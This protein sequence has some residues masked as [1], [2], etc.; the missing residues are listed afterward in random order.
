MTKAI[1]R[2]INYVGNGLNIPS[3]KKE[4]QFVASG[5]LDKVTG[6]WVTVDK[7]GKITGIAS[8]MVWTVK[9]G[10]N[11]EGSF[12]KVIGP[13]TNGYHITGISTSNEVATD[14]D[15]TT[16]TVAGKTI[17]HSNGDILITINYAKNPD[18][19]KPVVDQR[20]IVVT[21]HDIKNNQDVSGYTKDSGNE[22]V[23]TKFSYDTKGNI[24]KLTS[25]GYKV[26]NP[27]IKIPTTIS[28]GNQHLVIYVD[29]NVISVTPDKPGNGLKHDDLQ[30]TVT[31]TVK[32]VVNGDQSK[33]PSDKMASLHFN[34]TTYYDSVTKKW[35]DASGNELKD[36]TK[37]II[38]TAQDGNQFDTVIS[39]IVS[40]YHVTNVSDNYNDGNGN[41]KAIKNID[42]TSQD[43]TAIVTYDKDAEPTKNQG[44]LIVTVHDITDNKDLDKYG[45]N[46]GTQDVGTK[47]SYDKD[48]NIKTLTEKGYEV[49]NPDVTIPTE[50]TKGNHTVTI[51]VKHT[52]TTVTPE[53]PGKPGEPIDPKYPD[54]PKYPMGTDLKN[55]KETAT[56]IVHYV[57]AGDKTPADKTQTFDF[58]KKITFDNV[59]GK[60]I[61]DTDWNVTSHTFGNENT[62]V[63][64][65]YHADKRTAGGTTVSPDDLKKEVTVTYTPN[66]KIIPIDPDGKQIPDAPTPMYP[67]DSDDPTEVVANEPVPEIKDMTP[68]KDKV[69]P[70]DPAKDTPVI[71]TKDKNPVV[72][73]TPTVPTVIPD[74][75]KTTTPESPKTPKTPTPEKPTEPDK[76]D[77]PAVPDKPTKSKE[78]DVPKTTTIKHHKKQQKQ[79]NN[80]P[81]PTS[82]KPANW[83]SNNAPHGQNGDWNN[84]VLPHGE[85]I[86]SN[87]NII[88]PNG[89]VIGYIDKNGQAHYT[90]PQTGDDQRTDAAA[91]ILG[92][93]AAVAMSMIGLAGVKKRKED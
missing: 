9:G 67:T 34:G 24:D 68:E 92:G 5:V 30:K 8:G 18:T 64:N 51:L 54:G 13:K 39:P 74:A 12:A 33:A 77:K 71:Y 37:N 66:G 59:T 11:D 41:V 87:G 29:H 27:E 63:V 80:T 72:P 91:F 78:P 40:G 44:S 86:D 75:S 17:N 47:F 84:N 3:V 31:E 50:I 58:T 48:G 89:Q 2:T 83:S 35:T 70:Q 28:K 36:Q 42:Q 20:S 22:N 15:S 16:G 19:P 65:G 57:G 10:N 62:L 38:W 79:N 7:S 55:L 46:S 23:G 76:P 93:G 85:H 49:L 60:I 1:T 53:K 56:Q 26:L 88:G 52:T 61:A 21:V 82:N 32:Y 73:N 6:Q 43:F 25:A 69:T 90:L 81:K 45:K 14:V 4:I